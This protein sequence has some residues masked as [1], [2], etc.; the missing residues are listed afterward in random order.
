M[1]RIAPARGEVGDRLDAATGRGTESGRHVNVPAPAL[2]T[3]PR[4]PGWLGSLVSTDHKRL[5][6]N[7]GI[8]SLVFF[9]AGGVMALL[10]RVQLAQPQTHFLGDSAYNAPFTMHGSTIIYLFVTPLATAM[11]VYSEPLQFGAAS[12]A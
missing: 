11:C 9:L 4:G 7:M 6:L 10:M 5:G 1:A 2:T 12:T 3:L 8:A